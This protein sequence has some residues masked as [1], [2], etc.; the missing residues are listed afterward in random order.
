MQVAS[1]LKKKPNCGGD[2]I[3]FWDSIVGSKIIEAF[4]D[5]D[6]VM[7]NAENYTSWTRFFFSGTQPRRFMLMSLFMQDNAPSHYAKSNVAYLALTY[8]NKK[9]SKKS[10]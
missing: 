8:K 7:I 3:R 9:V 5:D 10:N 6:G 1:Q 2:R 4:K